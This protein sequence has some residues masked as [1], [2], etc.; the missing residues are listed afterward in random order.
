MKNC[1]VCNIQVEDLYTGLCPNSLCSWEF[2][3]TSSEITPE[4]LDHYRQKLE[5]TKS[6]YI[7]RSNEKHIDKNKIE[8]LFNI[9]KK[10]RSKKDWC[11]ILNITFSNDTNSIAFIKEEY[12][13]ALAV[14]EI[15]ISNKTNF[16]LSP[17]KVLNNLKSLVIDNVTGDFQKA[18]ERYKEIRNDFW[19]RN[20]Y[21]TDIVL[22]VTR[23]NECSEKVKKLETLQKKWYNIL[24]SRKEKEEINRKI[25]LYKNNVKSFQNTLNYLIQIDRYW[26][27]DFYA[28]AEFNGL[29]VSG[30]GEQL[31]TE[32]SRDGSFDFD[33]PNFSYFISSVDYPS[34]FTFY[35]VFHLCEDSCPQSLE[36]L[37]FKNMNLFY[38]SEGLPPQIKNIKVSNCWLYLEKED[39]IKQRLKHLH[40]SFTGSISAPY[41]F[42]ISNYNKIVTTKNCP[43]C[44]TQVEDQYIGLCP[45][46]DCI[47]DFNFIS[48]MTPEYRK[49]YAEKLVECR[50]LYELN[51]ENRLI[52]ERKDKEKEEFNPKIYRANII[53][54]IFQGL[55][56]IV[57]GVLIYIQYKSL[58]FPIQN[59]AL[60]FSFLGYLCLVF[61]FLFNCCD[62][63]GKDKFYRTGLL[64]C[65]IKEPI[66][67]I[68][69][70][71][72]VNIIFSLSE[73][74]WITLL[75]IPLVGIIAVVYFSLDFF[76]RDLEERLKK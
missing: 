9:I 54:F 20:Y 59:P 13:R 52:S 67:F 71:I 47:W 11:D 7:L 30:V 8:E 53:A 36:N 27:T 63:F 28:K 48:E 23:I 35:S 44:N 50:R 18:F 16:D 65:F 55:V 12:E 42:S 66:C 38:I 49:I 34:R 32:G 15:V 56:L 61:F 24:S 73:S 76:E 29:R 74:R 41:V 51:I 40:L 45:R 17:L 70:Y 62:L 64:N 39:H 25:N 46:T 43:V 31:R 10:S 22:C 33:L 14:E 3:F 68:V 72:G 60:P 5:K 57:S 37:E 75:L 69:G 21:N 58:F 19:N 26:Y 6:N 2:E 1:P 4:L